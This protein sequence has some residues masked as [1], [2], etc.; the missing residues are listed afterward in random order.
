MIPPNDFPSDDEFV[1][2]VKRKPDA[3]RNGRRRDTQPPPDDDDVPPPRDEDAPP[4]GADGAGSTADPPATPPMT[5]SEVLAVERAPIR[6][7]PTGL[8]RLDTLTGGGIPT[9]ALTAIVARTGAGKTGFALGL[10]QHIVRDSGVPALYVST[11][12]DADEAAAR[13]AALELGV[14]HRDILTGTISRAVAR[15][16]IE[17]FRL[18]V[19][20]W[21]GIGRGAAALAQL[22]AAARAVAALH[23]VPPLLVVDYLQ[24]LVEEDPRMVR[25]GASAIASGLRALGQELDTATIGVSST[26]RAFYRPSREAEDRDDPLFYLA[27]AKESGDIEF[28]AANVIFLDVAPEHTEGSYAA[29]IVVAKAR[30]GETG[31]VG[32]QFDGPSGRWTADETAL[33]AMTGAARG[34][35]AAERQAEQ[36]DQKVLVAVRQHGPRAWRTLRDLSG[37]GSGRA[38]RARARLLAG[39]RIEEGEE[40]YTDT[41]GRE[42]TRSVLRAT[43]SSDGGGR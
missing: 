14:P 34:A 26:A 39:G 9:R 18:H 32:A 12:L 1:A 37:V 33:R 23:G 43:A 21:D 7:Y 28:A 31:F 19:I 2:G 24:M 11:E 20:G 13:S 27:A 40:A 8:S 38:D 15:Q 6:V 10:A 17:G 42:R 5:A 36:D 25:L 35:K 3:G 22:R 16:A 30:R 4:G 29:R 41:A